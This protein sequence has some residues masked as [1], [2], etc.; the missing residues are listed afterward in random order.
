MRVLRPLDLVDQAGRTVGLVVAAD[1]VE[2]LPAVADQLAGFADIAGSSAP[3]LNLRQ[4]EQAEL[5]PCYPLIRGHGDLLAGVPLAC[6]NTS[7][8][9]AGAAWPR[10]AQWQN[11]ARTCQI[12]TVSEHPMRLYASLCPS[13]LFGPGPDGAP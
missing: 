11:E 2:L 7:A 5:A 1:L 13:R 8:T 6:G 9:P 12:N 3:R 4:L 10:P